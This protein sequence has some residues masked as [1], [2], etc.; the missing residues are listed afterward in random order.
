MQVSQPLIWSPEKWS[1][2]GTI[3]RNNQHG[4]ILH[5][6]AQKHDAGF[7]RY[8]LNAGANPLAT[9]RYG[10]TPWQVA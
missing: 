6:A 9:N 1:P 10:H 3:G 2:P 5:Y 4:S 8:V 7:V